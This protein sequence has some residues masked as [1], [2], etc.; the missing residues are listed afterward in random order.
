MKLRKVEDEKPKR[1][2]DP[3][4]K[5]STRTQRQRDRRDRLKRAAQMCG[6][7]TIDQLAAAIIDGTVKIV[8]SDG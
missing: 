6:Y 3:A 1:R 7:E 5:D 2:H 8:R 4:W